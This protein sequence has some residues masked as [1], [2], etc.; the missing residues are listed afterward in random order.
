V[1]PE[2]NIS[3]LGMLLQEREKNTMNL[4]QLIELPCESNPF[5]V[6][7]SLKGVVSLALAEER[8]EE[9][10]C[11]AGKGQKRFEDF[12]KDRLLPSS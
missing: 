3:S 7:S 5:T 9:I 8:K 1:A 10:L 4:R 11:Y 2:Q 6:E 12:V